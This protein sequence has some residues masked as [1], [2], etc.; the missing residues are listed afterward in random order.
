MLNGIAPVLIFRFKKI[1]IP[2]TYFEFNQDIIPLVASSDVSIPLFPIVIYLDPRLTGIHI[3]S[4][5]KHV[6]I[7]TT[8]DGDPKKSETTATQKPLN[9]V[10]NVSMVANKNSIGLNVILSMVDIVFTKVRSSEYTI[11]YVNGA[12]SIFGGL[13]E[14]LSVSQEYNTDKFQIELK[15]SNAPSGSTVEKT[16]EQSATIPANTGSVPN[17]G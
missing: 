14:G 15:V 12:M 9:S 17:L 11:D 16:A 7:Q 3:E 10:V 6:D 5:S 8:V 2:F 13:L 4:E 1:V